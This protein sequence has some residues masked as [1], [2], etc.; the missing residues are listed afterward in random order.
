MSLYPAKAKEARAAFMFRQVLLVAGFSPKDLRAAMKETREQLEAKQEVHFAYKG[1]V[2]ETRTVVDWKARGE[3]AERMLK[4]GGAYPM[5]KD[6]E[7]GGAGAIVV[8]VV[9]SEERRVGK[10]CRL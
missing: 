8:E 7:G 9:R 6:H 3:A 10:E 4:I 5:V 2:G 1:E